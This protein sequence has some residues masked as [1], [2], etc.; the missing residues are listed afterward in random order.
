MKT[1]NI[2]KLSWKPTTSD[3]MI[4]KEITCKL[5][6]GNFYGILGPNGSGKTSL[7]RHL[8]RLLPVKAGKIQLDQKD[9]TRLKQEE[10]AR[11]VSFVPQKTA[12]DAEFTVYD[13]VAM[14]RTPYQKH[15]QGLGKEDETI[16]LQAL[17]ATK[18]IHLK[19]QYFTQLSGGEAQRVLVARTIAQDTPWLVLDEPIA[20][21]DIKHQVDLMDTLRT[22]NR[23]KDKTVIAILHD[24]NLA[25]KYCNEII[26]M[27]DGEIYD[28]GPVEEVLTVKN[29]KAVYEID[30]YM[31]RNSHTGDRYFIPNSGGV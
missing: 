8:L 21:L 12:I 27:K 26:L 30:F 24:L 23:E 2:A 1:I 19:D 6:A 29:L 4:L 11:L 5:S 22:L 10:F 17:E 14:G 15:F 25:A 31:E 13:I 20:S 18:C 28:A 3:R 16:I 9:I 7:M